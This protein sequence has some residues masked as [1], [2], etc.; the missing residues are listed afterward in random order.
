MKNMYLVFILAIFVGLVGCASTVNRNAATIK[1]TATVKEEVAQVIKFS[2]IKSLSINLDSKA[3]EKLA[4][5]QNFNRDSLYN[6]ISSVLSASQYLQPQGNNSRLKL[7]IVITNIRVRSGA[8]AIILGVFAGADYITG[9]IY[10]KD[11]DKV[12]DN[13][14]VD[15]TYAFGGAAGDTDTRMNWMYESFASKILEELQ[16]LMPISK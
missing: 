2:P 4:D 7:D 15:I 10:L 13:F 3:Q 8:S 1:E 16:K 14:E 11:G 9:Q 12:I 5:N 6:K